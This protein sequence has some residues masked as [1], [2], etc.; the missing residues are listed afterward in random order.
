MTKLSRLF[1]LGFLLI[2]VSSCSHVRKGDGP[3]NFYVDESRIHNAVPKNEPLSRY[4]NLSSYR[5]KGKRYKVMKSSKNYEAVGIASWYGTLFHSRRTSSGE[6]YNMLAMTAAHKT[7]PLPTYVR[8]TNLSNHRQIIVKVNDRGPFK[9]GRIIDLSYVAAK[10]LG[11]MGRGTA[12]VRVTAINPKE[13]W[14]EKN[15]RIQ[16]INHYPLMASHTPRHSSIRLAS[17][18]RPTAARS[19]KPSWHRI[20]KHRPSHLQVKVK[21]PHRLAGRKTKIHTLNNV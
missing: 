13:Y 3:P 5:V 15:P 7:L 19:S 10:K 18:K 14:A 17:R 21:H 12:P 1:T 11:M 20:V 9:P 4:G 6:R 16:H 2:F 8:V